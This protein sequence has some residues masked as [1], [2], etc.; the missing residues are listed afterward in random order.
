MPPFF[1]ASE[2]TWFCDARVAQAGVFDPAGLD[3]SKQ[4]ILSDPAV[5]S[6]AERFTAQAPA[7]WIRSVNIPGGS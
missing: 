6:G 5:M 3:R 4:R 2:K 1:N 7:R